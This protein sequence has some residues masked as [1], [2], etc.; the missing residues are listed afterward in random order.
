MFVCGSFESYLLP[1]WLTFIWNA[2]KSF[3]LMLL[4]IYMTEEREMEFRLDFRFLSVLSYIFKLYFFFC[5]SFLFP[6][7][8]FPPA[9]L[10]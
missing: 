2:K 9:I 3:F 1:N 6:L 7:D 5:L 10:Q 4:K 8:R